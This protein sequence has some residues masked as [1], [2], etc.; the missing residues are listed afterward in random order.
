MTNNANL[1]S[2]IDDAIR[3]VTDPVGFYRGMERTGGFANPI[4]FLVVMSVLMGVVTALFSMFAFGL[5]GIAG[6]GFSAIFIMPIF[7]L[8]GSFIG[9][10]FMFVIWKL[11]GSEQSYETSYRCVAYASAIYPLTPFFGLIP[12]L[13]SAIAVIW[14][15]Y[16]MIIA[17]SEVHALNRRTA[18]IVFGILGI[19]VVA[20]NFSNEMA[21]R[22]MKS[23]IKE[24]EDRFQRFG[25]EPDQTNSMTPE[26]VGKTVGRFIRS[27]EQ[28]A[29]GSSS[30]SSTN[31]ANENEDRLQQFPQEPIDPEKL[32]SMAEDFARGFAKAT[33]TPLSSTDDSTFEANEKDSLE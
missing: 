25:E 3:V 9:S 19:I 4:I 12:Y 33:G 1:N 20:A 24:F 11:M 32:G 5:V 29:K 26:E 17:S 21:L 16:L 18:Y 27:L 2:I 15:F 28:A 7:T 31:D 13:G 10:A 14:G 6:A 23:N 22:Q 8:I 30:S